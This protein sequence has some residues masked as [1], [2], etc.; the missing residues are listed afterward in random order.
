MT[1]QEFKALYEAELDK[2]TYVEKAIKELEF[3]MNGIVTVH[4]KVKNAFETYAS[5][6]KSEKNNGYYYGFVAD[7]VVKNWDSF[8]DV[9]YELWNFPHMTKNSLIQFYEYIYSAFEMI[10]K[11]LFCFEDYI[12]EQF[13]TYLTN[14]SKF[15]GN[16]IVNDIFNTF[17][18]YLK[19]KDDWDEELFIKC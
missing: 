1:K 8:I 6:H 7:K 10:E 14:L 9:C 19:A 2:L 3:Q 5:N 4:N 12:D 16:D 13:Q 17:S 11:D 18:D 15:F